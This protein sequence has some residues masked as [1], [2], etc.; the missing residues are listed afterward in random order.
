MK[1][2][3]RDLKTFAAKPDPACPGLLIYGADPMR[4]ALQRQD[5]IAALLGP[6]EQD[7]MRLERMPAADLRRDPARLI[8]ALKAVGFFPG[9]RAVLLEDATNAQA[10]TV[11]SA[12]DAWQPGDAWLVVTA[13]ALR[14]SGL[15][16]LFEGHRTARAVAVYDDPPG[17]DE[18]E[19]ILARAGVATPDRDAMAAILSLGQSLDP[20]E[21]R[22]TV[23]KVALYKHNDPVPLTADEVALMAPRST[24]AEVDEVIHA[25]ADGRTGDI[26]PLLRRLAAQGAT[27]V[28]LAIGA[29]RHFRLLY[30]VTAA[31]GG[32]S[33][34][35]AK[36]RPPL[37]GPRRDRIAR[38]AREWPADRLEQAL[39][40][41]M[42][43]DLAIRSSSAAPGMAVIERALVRIAYLRAARR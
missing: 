11:A 37:Y 39:A 33:E 29:A 38:Q 16:K 1:L 17:R 21:F 22:Q 25:A 30:A 36:L 4:V 3:A 20:G 31:A 19:A 13:G 32:V 28:T 6:G 40:M 26:G 41:I 27:P 23:E 5:L 12:L 10:E 24:E 8:D 14:P 43:A 35:I 34:G 42:D 2:A 7:E 9:P 15:R 18:I